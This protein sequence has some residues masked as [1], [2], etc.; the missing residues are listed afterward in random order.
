MDNG[1]DDCLI[2]NE[3]F[4]VCILECRSPLD[5]LSRQFIHTSQKCEVI[6]S[7]PTKFAHTTRVIRACRMHRMW[8]VRVACVSSQRLR[9]ELARLAAHVE[10]HVEAQPN[11]RR[12][13]RCPR[14]RTRRAHRGGGKVATTLLH[15]T[16]LL[17]AQLLRGC[18]SRQDTGMRR[19]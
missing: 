15:G 17:L 5:R 12:A 10:A 7:T 14:R 6:L 4:N 9:T 8:G 1:G 11:M 3:N 19:G 16:V 18:T 13:A 2:R